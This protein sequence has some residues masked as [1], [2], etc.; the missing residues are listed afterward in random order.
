M[1]TLGAFLKH[2]REEAGIS[3][4]DLAA[5][6]RIRIENLRSL[7]GEDLDSLPTD[8][9]VRGFV[10]L[11]CRE[12]GLEPADGLVRYETLRRRSGPLDEIT[13]E[14]EKVEEH[15]GVLERALGDPDRIVRIGAKSARW[16]GF[17]VAALAIVTVAVLAFRWL[18]PFAPRAREPVAYLPG[19]APAVPS[20][21]LTS[22]PV[23]EKEAPPAQ[24]S[25]R[26]SAPPKATTPEETP[27]EVLA[28][29]NAPVEE[30]VAAIPGPE[31]EL[32]PEPAAVEQVPAEP[33]APRRTE[34]TGSR[35]AGASLELRVEA[36]RPV[37]VTVLLDGVGHPR[38]A[39]L[40]VGNSKRW[41]ADHLFVLSASDGGALRLFLQGEDL[42]L[43]GP[44]GEPVQGLRVRPR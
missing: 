34:I 37:D 8:P 26:E 3:L 30:I 39:S 24:E 20:P 35:P 18:D 23:P 33:P 40:A 38:T 6:T 29:E 22:P 4:E 21:S 32:P 41:K 7:E 2:G 19:E 43:A 25:A 9:Y 42:G 10:K 28:D 1:E 31:P 16:A 27:A 12:L 13:W 17:A 44:S 14:E 36:V 5:R 15:P 11:V